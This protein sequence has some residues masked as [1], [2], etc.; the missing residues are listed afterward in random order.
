M[1]Y[2]LLG[3]KGEKVRVPQSLS[4][5]GGRRGNMQ[6]SCLPQWFPFCGSVMI[7]H[8]LIQVAGDTTWFRGPLQRVIESSS[9]EFLGCPFNE[10]PECISGGDVFPCFRK[11]TVKVWGL[12]LGAGLQDQPYQTPGVLVTAFSFAYCRLPSISRHTS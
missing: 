9:N 6:N 5:I 3:E 8:K 7:T 11:I 10:S 4:R 1:R 2:P 12:V